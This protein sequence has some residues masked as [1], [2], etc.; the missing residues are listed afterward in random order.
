MIAGCG[1]VNK[2]QAAGAL[3]SDSMPPMNN[4]SEACRI[5]L[6]STVSVYRVFFTVD[7]GACCLVG[8]AGGGRFCARLF[9]EF[10]PTVATFPLRA[11]LARCAVAFGVALAVGVRFWV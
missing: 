7:C 6:N 3:T 1:G 11:V 4:P 10:L 8:L 2:L 9:C 5:R